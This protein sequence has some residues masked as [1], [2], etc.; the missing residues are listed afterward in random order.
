MRPPAAL[1]AL[2]LA[3]PALPFHIPTAQPRAQPLHAPSS[4]ARASFP[5]PARL[6]ASPNNWGDEPTNQAIDS[7]NEALSL[8]KNATLANIRQ[9]YDSS[10][11][12]FPTSTAALYSPPVPYWPRL[13]TLPTPVSGPLSGS[14]I[15]LFKQLF[16][17]AKQRSPHYASDWTTALQPKNLPKVMSA[18]LFLFFACLS[19]AVSFGAI[20]L[21]VTGGTIGVVEFILSCSLSGIFYALFSGQPMAFLAP[22]GLTL[23]FITALYRFCLTSS[24]PFLPIYAY[25]GLWTSFFQL[26]TAV[27][28]ASSLIKYCTRFTDDVFNALLGANFV[29]EASASLSRDFYAAGADLTKPFVESVMGLSTFL[30]TNFLTGLRKTS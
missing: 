13:L 16:A 11:Q 7:A 6:A 21:S 12:T 2:A 17:D 23:A 26:L 29:Y 1:L 4:L 8:A 9:V 18:T 15:Y 14:P 19:P 28:G 22:T 25:V 30:L 27:T 5:P 10:S 20:A 24:L 3:S